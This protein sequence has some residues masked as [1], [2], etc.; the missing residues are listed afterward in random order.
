M[1]GNVSK[2]TADL[3]CSYDGDSCSEAARV[4]RGGGW[5]YSPASNMR[6]A[7]REQSAPWKLGLMVGFRCARAN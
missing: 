5:Y 2:W 1:A 7:H 4:M 3:Y 6:G